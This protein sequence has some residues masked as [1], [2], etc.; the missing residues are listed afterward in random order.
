MSLPK[1]FFECPV[2]LR[3][4][5][6]SDRGCVKINSKRLLDVLWLRFFKAR[7]LICSRLEREFDE[8]QVK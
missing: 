2:F 5:L 1:V 3:D 6:S 7:A 4:H 8:V